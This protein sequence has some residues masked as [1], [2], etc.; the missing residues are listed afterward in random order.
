LGF[1][2]GPRCA[3]SNDP[4]GRIAGIRGEAQ[5][6]PDEI[7]EEAATPPALTVQQA[8]AAALQDGPDSTVLEADLGTDRG[9]VVWEVLIRTPDGQ[10]ELYIDAATREIVKREAEDDD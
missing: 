5:Q 6:R 8:I 9:I 10:V 2:P 1:P 4:G 7:S 3:F